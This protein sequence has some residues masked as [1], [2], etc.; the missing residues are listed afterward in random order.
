[1]VVQEELIIQNWNHLKTLWTQPDYLSIQR[2][3]NMAH[4]TFSTNQWGHNYMANEE[5]SAHNGGGNL[6]GN[7]I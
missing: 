7:L 5:T 2:V 4:N 6:V 1:M 3:N